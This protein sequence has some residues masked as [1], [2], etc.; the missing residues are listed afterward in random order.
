MLEKRWLLSGVSVFPIPGQSADRSSWYGSSHIVAGPDG[1]LWFTDSGNNQIDRVTPQGQVTTFSLPTHTASDGT[2]DDPSPD[3]IV[4]GPDGNLWFTEFGVD[5]I[6]RITPSG[7]IT[8]FQTPTADSNPTGIAVGSDGN[9]WFIE[10]GWSTE[11]GPNA[12]GRITPAGSITEYPTTNLYLNLTDQMVKRPGGNLWFIAYD[13]NGDSEIARVNTAGKVTAFPLSASPNDI[14]IGRDGN[15]WLGSNGE[16]DR[17]AADGSVT[18]FTIPTGDDASAIASSP[19]G[20][21]WFAL[22]GTNQ[23]GRMTLQG[24]FSEYALPEPGATDGSTIVIGG[25][26]GGP[27]GNLWF[28]DDNVPHVGQISL[29]TALLAGGNAAIETAGS[30]SAATLATF[31]DFSGASAASDYSAS[32]TWNDGTTSAGTIT[33][34][35]AGGFD[36][37]AN[38]DWTLADAAPAITI[39]DL[40]NPA[41]TASA[42]ASLT[43]NPPQ[44]IGTGMSVSTTAAALFSG[45]VASFT[46]VALNSLSK[47]SATIDWG[48]G[49]VSNGTITANSSGGIDVSGSNRYAASGT[50]TITVNL[51]PYPGGFFYPLGGGGGVE[52]VALGA[53][54]SGAN[55]TGTG[56]ANGGTAGPSASTMPTNATGAGPASAVATS[57]IPIDPLPPTISPGFATATSTMTVA[58]GVMNGTGFTVQASSTDAFSG[59]VASFQ[60]ADPSADLSH[61]HAT[62]TWSNPWVYD[63][64]T[65]SA[66]PATGTITPNGQGG[67]TVSV[68]TSFSSY[69]LSHFTV[70]IADDRVTSGDATV[71]VAYG[72]LSVDSPF[73]WLPVLESNGANIPAGAASSVAA[74]AASTAASNVNPV[75][76]EQVGESNATL[77]PGAGGL[78]AGNIGMFHGVTSTAKKLADLHGTI[79]WGDGTT[80]AA[81]FVKGAKGNI[82]V[83]GSHR[84]AATGSYAV[85]VSAQQTLYT[86]GKPSALYPMELPAIQETATVI[87][88]GAITTGG[89]AISATAGQAFT[90]PVANFAMPAL[91]VPSIQA[92]TVFW[93]DGSRSV[94]SI[95]IS[96]SELTVTGTHTYR[97]AGKYHVRVI[98]TQHSTQHGTALPLL[99]ANIASSAEVS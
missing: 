10:S 13:T 40:R 86:D 9:L 76:S 33:A 67:F 49:Q 83:R 42:T 36:V 74:S 37:S 20:A 38:R 28:T 52:P 75:L 5:R 53:P 98:V 17:V 73:R 30:S 16:I 81:I 2:T 7:T 77:H 95:A 47:Y 63:W 51:S 65:C 84:Y 64:F 24:T 57:S 66:P 44:P 92:A 55:S 88:P 11:N 18:P 46:G 41:R 31:T 99:L 72:Q 59:V 45:T 4:A 39:T 50:Y 90:G 54:V 19:D 14:T 94:G 21:L 78:V 8:E 58:P 96:G 56:T 79:D 1:N 25:I 80:S 68:S 26:T 43:V 32:I 71:G 6:G 12:V 82:F 70:T 91:N 29:S 69:G 62:V 97:K 22:D 35:P 34:D 60:L 27:D 3:D 15:V 87:K 48:D 61:F 23:I 85:S 89:I 93:G